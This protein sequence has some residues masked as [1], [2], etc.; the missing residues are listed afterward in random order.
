MS[1]AFVEDGGRERS[2]SNGQRVY[3][4]NMNTLHAT[5]SLP[6][7][8]HYTHNE[9][10]V[11]AP[12]SSAR[13][14]AGSLI[15]SQSNHDGGESQEQSRQ[16]Q[17]GA[18]R[19]STSQQQPQ[20]G[21]AAVTASGEAV[22]A[23]LQDV[24]QRIMRR[25][26]RRMNYAELSRVSLA[27][28]Y[29]VD[30]LL[31][32][33]RDEE[34]LQAAA[35]R[36]EQRRQSTKRRSRPSPVRES[37][38]NATSMKRTTD[39]GDGDALTRSASRP[40][41]DYQGGM[42]AE[43]ES[44][45]LRTS[46]PNTSRGA[47]GGAGAGGPSRLLQFKQMGTRSR[48]STVAGGIL[49]PAASAVSE[50]SGASAA[51]TAQEGELENDLA[52]QPCPRPLRLVIR[53]VVETLQKKMS[54]AEGGSMTD[55]IVFSFESRALLDRLLKEIPLYA[56]YNA[57][58]GP[59]GVAA[60]P[61]TVTAQQQ[62]DIAQVYQELRKKPV[63]LPRAGYVEDP[64]TGAIRGELLD[65][66]ATRGESVRASTAA[67]PAAAAVV[68][69]SLP[70]I[71]PTARGLSIGG[72]GGGGGVAAFMSATTAPED[73]PLPSGY[74]KSS[75]LTGV[76]HGGVTAANATAAPIAQQQQ[77][78]HRLPVLRDHLTRASAA[79]AARGSPSV[80]EAT[81]APDSA[82]VTME[83]GVSCS[84]FADA[85]PPAGVALTAF[86]T[87][88]RATRLVSVG[89]TTEENGLTT[90][91]MVDHVALQ[92]RL[93]A[94]EAEL[95]DEKVHRT[96]L[97]DQLCTE[98]HYTDQKKR[99]LQYLRETL[100]R[101]CAMLRAQLRLASSRVLQLQ[102]QQQQQQQHVP[103]RGVPAA[104]AASG[105]FDP[106][107]AGNASLP[108]S[109][110]TRAHKQSAAAGAST[111]SLSPPSV[112]LSRRHHSQRLSAQPR[113]SYSGSIGSVYGGGGGGGGGRSA[114]AQR[115][116]STGSVSL[117]ASLSVAPGVMSGAFV[118]GA[119]GG[120]AVAAA[121]DA[122]QSSDLEAV[123][124]LLDLVLLAVEED[125]VVPHHTLLMVRHGNTDADVVAS[126]FRKDPKQQIDELRTE[127]DE[128]QNLLKK[129][130][131]ARTAEQNYI[132]T[133]QRREVERLRALTDT[134]RVRAILQ[135]HVTSLRTELHQLR[136]YV[137]EQLHFF[138]AILQ[139]TA[140]SLLRRSTL[141]D[142]TLGENL[143]L[144]STVSAMREMIESASALLMPMLTNEY[145]CG[146]HPWPLKLRN[147]ID[148]LSH[149]IHL[150]YGA[151]EVVRLRD[152]LNI[153]GQ[154]Y[155]AMHRFIMH[156]V[157][158]PDSTRPSAGKPLQQLCGALALNPLS[159]TDVI[160]AA[161]HAYDAE[162]QLC[163]RLARLNARLLW[164]AHLQ[165]AFTDRSVAALVAAGLNPRFTA[166]PVAGRINLLAQERAALLQARVTVQRER[167]ENAKGAY[168]LWREKEI[169]ISEGYPTPQTQRNRLALLSGNSGGNNTMAVGGGGLHGQ[170]SSGV[171]GR[172]SKSFGRAS[173][174]RTDGTGAVA[175]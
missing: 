80:S 125:A 122:Q 138:K 156:Q 4:N 155:C 30:L 140:Q 67:V 85:A 37:V 78:Q 119:G 54:L 39:R 31:E 13:Q 117:G 72:G 12:G 111:T 15:P 132:V 107:E 19:A 45:L 28:Q 49:A 142:K 147:T 51:A 20:R 170:W 29:G 104:A 48:P 154:L 103:P 36:Q 40:F 21:A 35:G 97:A 57:S 145:K 92:R 38:N 148:P 165:R 47:G 89:T 121:I 150:R 174:A 75:R 152:S 27:E 62:Q 101:E 59:V 84:L 166:L 159:H 91:P 56:Q 108:A 53:H 66:T 116:L 22:H 94:L 124:S 136:T 169:D 63:L 50:P 9:R 105:S 128:R 130:M 87:A 127:F 114:G 23:N 153:F 32:C 106:H 139:N 163:R 115:Q 77:Q 96:A 82:A 44:P 171:V 157:V 55:C 34:A 73:L 86:A 113:L 112:G 149:V 60:G 161:R 134:T 175:M 146:Y 137:A 42:P 98:A 17:R 5:T 25:L 123:Q 16:T 129:S 74:G 76:A 160:F 109:A 162:V 64:V 88:H 26:Q 14:Y 168:R 120:S 133:E 70:S 144:T 83:A 93:E 69:A 65:V 100:V 90:V 126:G 11:E 173:V 131:L 1:R 52:T 135:Q 43:R 10:N 7:R 33:E 24:Y 61:P 2:Q 143:I 3:V 58:R 71:A 41:A 141:V 79:S 18:A 81:A 118:P 99:V 6:E 8:A 68:A 46:S 102:Q 110:A 158:L 172:F 95:A 151:G 164:N 167:A